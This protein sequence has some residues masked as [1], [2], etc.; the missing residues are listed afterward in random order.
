VL[1][2]I[3]I[4][5]ALTIFWRRRVVPAFCSVDL[6]PLFAVEGIYLFF[7]I[8][9]LCGYYGFVRYAALLQAAF[10]LS[11]LLPVLRRKLYLPALVGAGLTICGS[12]L[13][14]LVIAANG[15]KMPVRPSLSLWT[16]YYRPG[17]LE[18]GTDALHIPMTDATRLNFLADYIDT[19]FSVM[20]IG[21]LLIHSFVSV[22][23]FYTLKA[24][25]N[26]EKK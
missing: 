7:Q 1:L 10:L 8:T 9:A 16:G 2:F 14:R 24:L 4:P 22:I 26:T 20:S 6:Y 17:M 19:G 5:F 12:L 11:L 23:V 21:D 13:N 15:G 25:P 3:L 18:A